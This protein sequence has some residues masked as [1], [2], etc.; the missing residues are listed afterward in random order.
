METQLRDVNAQF[1]RLNGLSAAHALDL[2]GRNTIRQEQATPEQPV[3]QR[4]PSK[5]L[6]LSMTAQVGRCS[7]R[8]AP[9]LLIL[10][11]IPSGW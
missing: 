9:M 4:K 8:F 3:L 5:R 11:P 1:A 10:T 2:Y 6:P 7:A